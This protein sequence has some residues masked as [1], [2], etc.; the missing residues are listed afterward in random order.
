MDLSDSQTLT[1]FWPFLSNYLFSILVWETTSNH[2][3][4]LC[5]NSNQWV[6]WLL[7]S[8]LSAAVK[9]E[10][11]S[12]DIESQNPNSSSPKC[13]HHEQHR[14]NNCSLFKCK[15]GWSFILLSQLASAAALQMRH[16]NERKLGRSQNSSTVLTHARSESSNILNAPPPF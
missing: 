11:N 13:L 2:T 3:W 12:P 15:S 7:D 6:Q 1:Q 14:N 4:K 5:M 8:L 16:G 10:A 9:G